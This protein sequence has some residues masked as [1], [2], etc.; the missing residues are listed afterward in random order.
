MS[1]V[2]GDGEDEV[3]RRHPCGPGAVAGAVGGGRQVHVGMAQRY[4][5][6]EGDD[7]RHP[8]VGPVRDGDEDR[9]VRGA[10]VQE[11]SGDVVGDRSATGEEGAEMPDVVPLDE[12]GRRH[13][14]G[15]ARRWGQ[16]RGEEAGGHPAGARQG[17]RVAPDVSTDTPVRVAVDLQRLQVDGQADGRAQ[18]VPGGAAPSIRSISANLLAVRASDS[19]TL[20][21]CSVEVAVRA[22]VV[23]TT[24]WTSS[25]RALTDSRRRSISA[26][27]A[28]SCANTRRSMKP[29][30]RCPKRFTVRK[31]CRRREERQG[32]R[33]RSVEDQPGGQI[34]AMATRWRA[35]GRGGQD[36]APMRR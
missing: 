8:G 14:D 2:V 34:R 30:T 20:N 11:R 35:A 26:S 7:A 10:R 16:L 17:G 25:R 13:L 15:Q 22:A 36:L 27:W 1:G 4:Q 23:S 24:A 9:W 12:S 6:E 5:V 3:G 32:F 33:S 31:D 18:R 28:C 19:T 29:S 21:D